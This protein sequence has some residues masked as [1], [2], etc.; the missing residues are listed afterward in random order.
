MNQKRRQ[1]ESCL[2]DQQRIIQTQNHI[3]WIMQL[4]KNILEDDEQ[5]FQRII[6]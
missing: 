3:F 5:H 2:L 4:S 6:A 1:I